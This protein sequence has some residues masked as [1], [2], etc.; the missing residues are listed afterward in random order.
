[1]VFDE[2]LSQGLSPVCTVTDLNVPFYIYLSICKP[3]MVRVG[4]CLWSG[5]EGP[6]RRGRRPKSEKLL[7]LQEQDQQGSGSEM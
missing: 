5:G 1:M 7:L 4:L 6:K 2:G 3:N